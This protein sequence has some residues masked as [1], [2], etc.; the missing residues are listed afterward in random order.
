MRRARSAD[1]L[2]SIGKAPQHLSIGGVLARHQNEWP[3]TSKDIG[4]C[5]PLRCRHTWHSGVG[6]PQANDARRACRRGS[7]SLDRCTARTALGRPRCG[8]SPPSRLQAICLWLRPTARIRRLG[9]QST[10][11]RRAAE[12]A[13]TLVRIRASKWPSVCR[14]T[15]F[16]GMGYGEKRSQMQ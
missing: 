10:P 5:I 9:T 8:R 7:Q 4:L 14:Q 16:L 11:L 2:R 1:L 3:L 15:R 13:P 12:I 6:S